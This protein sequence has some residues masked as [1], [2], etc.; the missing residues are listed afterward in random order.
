M[1]RWQRS[2]ARIRRCCRFPPMSGARVGRI[3]E[4]FGRKIG[5]AS[6]DHA[7]HARGTWIPPG[8]ALPSR[9]GI[10]EDGACTAVAADR[11]VAER[12]VRVANHRHTTQA[13]SRAES[14]FSLYIVADGSAADGTGV[15]ARSNS[16]SPF[17]AD[18]ARKSTPRRRRPANPQR[19][20]EGRPRH[21][22][23]TSSS[24]DRPLS[25]CRVANGT[26]PQV[27]ERNEVKSEMRVEPRGEAKRILFVTPFQRA[28]NQPMLVSLIESAEWTLHGNSVLAKVAASSTM[29]EM[30]FTAR[31]AVSP[32]P[33]QRQAVDRSR[34]KWSRAE[35]R[36]R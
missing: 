36:R 34:C 26:V 18:S 24:W 5:A 14:S 19:S 3:A 32:A 1:S 17:A 27:A 20:R 30:S 13:N 15:S 10:V 7:A 6:T 22:S 29:I 9:T 4:L 2:R 31:R 33:R 25:D 23:G 12:G 16:V 21:T 8:T 28:R 11:T 35:R